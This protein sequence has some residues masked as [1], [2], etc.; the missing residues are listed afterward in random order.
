MKL[1]KYPLSSGDKLLT[2]EFVS[3]GRK[4]LIHKFVSYQPTNLKNVY[5]LAFG[6]KD[7]TTGTIDDLVISN[8]GDSEMVLTTVVAT[9]YAFTDKYPRA[10]I[11]AT[12]S[13]KA[14][15]RLYRMGITKF[16]SEF[17]SDFE[18]LGERYDDWESFKK[19]VEYDGFLVRRKKKK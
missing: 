14:R 9:V 18:I 5:N 12:G 7:H 1:P 13:T 4:G 3:E 8:N 11:Y 16:L 6:D 2:F 17:S 19:N 10:W 15:T